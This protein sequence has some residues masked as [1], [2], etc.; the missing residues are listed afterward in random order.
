MNINSRAADKSTEILQIGTEKS[1][2]YANFI[3]IL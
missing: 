3:I 2:M 1:R